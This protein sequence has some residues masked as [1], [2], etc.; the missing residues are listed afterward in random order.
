M[1]KI[2]IILAIFACDKAKPLIMVESDA[3]VIQ[4]AKSMK[5]QNT[6]IQ[7]TFEGHLKTCAGIMKNRSCCQREDFYWDYLPCDQI[8]MERK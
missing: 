3:C 5:H 4:C 7:I 8:E 2:L 6:D 1:L